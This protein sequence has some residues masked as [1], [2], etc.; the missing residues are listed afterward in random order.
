MRAARSLLF[1]ALLPLFAGCNILTLQSS[2]PDSDGQSRMQGV[3]VG[4]SGQLLFRACGEQRRFVVKDVGNTSVLQEAA[5]LAD[6]SGQ[7]YAD[8][9]GSFSANK[10]ATSEGQ[11]DLSKIYRL[12]RGANACNDPNF[13]LMTVH[14]SGE[15]WDLKA[16]GKGLELNR[17]GQPPFAVPYV[18]EQLPDGRFSLSTEANGQ[19]VELWVAPQRCVDPRR[20]SVESLSAELRVNGQVQ[21]GCAYFGGAHTD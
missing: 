5:S 14:A 10:T 7:V 3:L 11:L 4:D 17:E 13:K 19:K 1:V 8:L 20:G 21:Q 15:K 16:S 2:T 6:K 9:R 18:E 12:Q